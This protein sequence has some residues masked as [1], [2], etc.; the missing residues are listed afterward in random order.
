M[1][2]FEDAPGSLPS[3]LLAVLA[4]AAAAAAASSGGA[5]RAHAVVLEN[6]RVDLAVAADLGPHRDGRVARTAAAAAAAGGPRPG[7]R[8]GSLVLAIVEGLVEP[9]AHT[10]PRRFGTVQEKTCG[11]V[12]PGCNREG[13][14]EEGCALVVLYFDYGM[15]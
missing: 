13:S 1:S 12:P 14:A 4:T 5:A 10:T 6:V 7:V 3:S 8:Q 2:V 15:F 11:R 9:S